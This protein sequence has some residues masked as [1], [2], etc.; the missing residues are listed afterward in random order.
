MSG[1]GLQ[2]GD[3][4][5]PGITG[6]NLDEYGGLEH[7]HPQSFYYYLRKALVEC[8]DFRA[9]TLFAPNGE[10]QDLEEECRKYERRIRE[11]GGIELQFLGIGTNG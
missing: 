3:D 2:T 1:G 4:I 7:S 10:A 9:E 6:F 11:Q 5:P 8:T